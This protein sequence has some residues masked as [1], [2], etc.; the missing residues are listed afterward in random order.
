MSPLL[1][2][3]IART[4]GPV[5]LL[6]SLVLLLRGH[7]HP[8][9]GFV[10]GLMAASALTLY[11]TAYGSRLTAKMVKLA[12]ER[13]AAFGLLLAAGSG[14]VGVVDGRQFLLGYWAKITLPGGE[15]LEVGTPLLFDAGVYLVVIGATLG[16]VLYLRSKP[17]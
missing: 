3:A 17:R 12:P 13:I 5:L 4:I 6:F 1:P 2:Q 16:F 10:G 7:D 9:G 8:G 11:L 14:A 15:E